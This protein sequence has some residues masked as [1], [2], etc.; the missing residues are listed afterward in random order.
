MLRY[1]HL[2]IHIWLKAEKQLVSG[3]HRNISVRQEG[4][5]RVS[6]GRRIPHILHYASDGEI[7][8]HLSL[9]TILIDII[10]S[11]QPLAHHLVGAEESLCHTPRDD[12]AVLWNLSRQ[13]LRSRAS[14]DRLETMRLKELLI[15]KISFARSSNHF[16]CVVNQGKSAPAVRYAIITYILIRNA[17]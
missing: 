9:Q 16:Q 7:T 5:V 14:L 8:F 11:C 3:I 13:H 17:Y 12:H 1:K 6:L 4:H 15:L 10:D 2:C